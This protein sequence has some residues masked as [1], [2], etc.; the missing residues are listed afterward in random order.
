MS[1]KLDAKTSGI[2]LD[3]FKP[4]TKAIDRQSPGAGS[5]AEAGGAPGRTHT[6]VGIVMGAIAGKDEVSKRLADTTSELHT[7]KERLTE[8]EGA[9]VARPLDPK[10]IQRSRWANRNAAEWSTDDF[11]SFKSEI[12]TSG[13]NVQPIK[14]R[15][16]TGAVIDGQSPKY[17]IVYGH[18]R[19]R[20]CLELG[21]M[22]NA[23]VVQE[24]SDKELFTEM[25]RENRGRKNLS[26][27]EQGCM[28]NDAIKEGLYPSIRQLAEANAVNLSDAVRWVQLAKLPVDVV[29][30]FPSPLD[31]QVR[32]AKPLTDAMQRSPDAV[33]LVARELKTKRGSI[34]ATEAFEQLVGKD[35][36]KGGVVEIAF[37]GKKVAAFKPGKKGRAVIE[38]EAGALQESKHKALIK[39]IEDFL[40]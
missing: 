19:H 27:W 38:F 12:Q 17:E 23:I 9:T 1:K 22:V 3:G 25:D 15:L 36:E 29:E 7:A 24:M 26:A 10:L 5:Q 2:S 21:L 16:V 40:R 13:G 11:Q 33:L 31:L 18:R 34:T 4:R 28:Y 6:G 8:F 30:A 20:A 14:V 32:W 35:N 37:E 39:L